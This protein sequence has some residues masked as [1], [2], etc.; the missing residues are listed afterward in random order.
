MSRISF[1]TRGEGIPLILLHG[2]GGSVHHWE[3]VANTLSETYRVV[4][5]NLSH[6]FMGSDKLFFSVQVEALAHFIRENF[7]NEQVHVAGLSYGG[8]MAWALASQ[9]PDLVSRLVMINPMVPEPIRHFMPTE[10]RFFFSI[11]LNLKTIFVLLSSPM[12]KAFLKRSAQLFRDERSEG[13]GA[14][15]KLTGRKLQFVAHMIHNFAWILRSED[16]QLWKKKLLTYRGQCCLIYDQNDLLFNP[17]IY[18]KF[19]MQM[20]CE[21]LVVLTGAGHLAIKTEPALIA[22]KIIDFIQRTEAA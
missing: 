5:P 20:G 13:P 14:V 10:L 18:R 1:R 21:D 4:V 11:P 9:H 15:D 7:P 8:A 19:A 16:W 12:G 22:A 3:A 17:E 6:L 2:Y